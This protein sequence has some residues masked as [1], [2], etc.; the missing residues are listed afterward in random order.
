[1]RVQA[2]IG[3]VYFSL[4]LLADSSVLPLTRYHHTAWTSENGVGAVYDIQ[5]APNGYLWLTTSKGVFRFDGVAFRSVEEVT[6]GAAKTRNINAVYVSASGGVWLSTQ[7]AGLLLWKDGKLTTY[8]DRRCTPSLKSGSVSEDQEGWLWVQG[9]AGLYRTNGPVCEEID[10]EWG[11]PG[12]FV[13]AVFADR[14]GTVWVKTEDGPVLV[15]PR[16][17]SRF[18]QS[19]KRDGPT[20]HPGLF[21]Q[22]PDGSMWFLDDLGLRCITCDGSRATALPRPARAGYD[23]SADFSF[24]ADSS[25]WMVTNDGLQHF[26]RSGMLLDSVFGVQ[27]GLSSN[28]VR[29]ILVDVE[30]SVWVGTNSGLDRLRRNALRMVALPQTQEGQFAVATG[31]DGSVWTGNANLPLTQVF[32]DG[33]TVEFKQTAGTYVVRRDPEGQIWSAGALHLWHTS[34]SGLTRLHYPRDQTDDVVSIAVDRNREPW[35]S[36]IQQNVDHLSHGVWIN[37]NQALGRRRGVLGAMRG[38]D[39]GNVWF[40]FSRSVVKWDGSQYQK[41]SFPD[42]AMDISVTTIDVRGDHVWLGGSGGILLFTA[43]AFRLLKWKD[44]EGPGRVSG[45][46]ETAEGDLWVNGFSGVTHVSAVELKKWLQDPNH[47]VVSER[48]D[49]LDGLPGLSAD[50]IPEPSIVESRDG[51]LWIATTKGICWLDPKTFAA[52]RNRVPPPVVIESLYANGRAYPALG[53]LRLQPSTRTL[54]IHYA[55]LSMA[56]PER[57]LFRYRLDGANEDWQDVGTRRQA[58]YNRLKPGSYRFHVIACNQDGVWNEGGATW[59][60]SITPAFYQ[61]IWFESLCL[62]AAAA[63]VWYLYR[64]RLRQMTQRLNVRM[65]ERLNERTRIAR[66]L[67][68]TLLQSLQGVLLKFDAATYLIPDSLNETRN[69]FQGIIDEARQAVN[70]GRDAVQG[71]RS[72]TTGDNDLARAI[73][74]VGEE[75]AARPVEHCPALSVSSHGDSRDLEPLVRDEVY[76]IC[77]EA[78]RNSFAHAQAARIETEIH[79]EPRQFRLLV[80]DNGR[81]IDPKVLDSGGRAGHHGLPGLRERAALVGGKLAVRSQLGFGTEIELAI[82]ATLAYRKSSRGLARRTGLSN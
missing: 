31:N 62:L 64:L 54:E 63:I 50:R 71:L 22:A 68:D 45:V 4:R 14:Q 19:E 74:A 65:E 42:P 80:R 13:P 25:I 38:D 81:G 33:R 37:Q 53:D 36:T 51:R 12:G 77:C 59:T 44:P 72:S 40:S 75:L 8:T 66:D 73:A 27:Q 52:E 49:A 56:M 10:G 18:E 70:E 29:K 5:Q 61:R 30:G 67:H 69:R 79:Y 43:G 23:W 78:V 47:E 11:Y 55:A 24:A 35:I 26:D 9:Q 48:L 57:V 76:R 34:G 16:G 41:Y 7:S 58:F 60:Y 32:P 15:R 6:N 17:A 3:I 20:V 28:A 1:V 39:E 82:P 2:F 21:H 46:L